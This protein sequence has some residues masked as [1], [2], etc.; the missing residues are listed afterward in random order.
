MLTSASTLVDA[1]SGQGIRLPSAIEAPASRLRVRE[2]VQLA[3][4]V[5]ADV[6]CVTVA[7]RVG[8]RAPAGELVLL[9]ERD[10]GP[11]R[12]GAGVV[13]HGGS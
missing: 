11:R 3:A 10:V 5:E 12:G 13:G 9:V 4:L 2:D 8:E 7:L 1:V 6:G